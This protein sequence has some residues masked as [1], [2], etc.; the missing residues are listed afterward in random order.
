MN[1]FYK[2]SD[3]DNL[4]ISEIKHLYKNYINPE[5]VNIYNA[6]DYN[7]DIFEK[8]EGVYILLRMEKDF[9]FNWRSR[10]IKPWPQSQM[11]NK[12]RIKFQKKNKIEI[13]KL[14]LSPYIA[15]LGHNISI[16]LN[17]KLKKSY[18]VNSGAE[19]NEG[20]IKMAYAS[21]RN[22]RDYILSASNSFHGKLIATGT[23]TGSLKHLD[24]PKMKNVKFFEYNNFESLIKTI[25][26][27]KKQKNECNVYAI[28]IEPF[29]AQSLV[30]YDEHFIKKTRKLCDNENI[31]LIF[32]EVYCGWGKT[33]HVFSFQRYKYYPDILTFSKSFG[34]GKSSI[35]GY[36][37]KDHVFNKAYGNKQ[38]ALLHT[39]TYNGFAEECLTAI[40]AINILVDDDYP[41]KANQIGIIL[42][43]SL[44]ILKSKHPNSV[45]EIK[46]M[47]ALYGV[48]FYSP[49]DIFTNFFKNIPV[50]FIQ[51]KKE[52]IEKITI[53]SIINHLYSNHNILT[54]VTLNP[55]N[56]LLSVSPSLVITNEDI[57]YFIDS[58]DKTLQVGLSKLVFNFIKTNLYKLLQ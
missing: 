40:E 6:F 12:E 42:M 7:D 58:L 35:S 25:D 8:A 47:G 50:A 31:N 46:G 23:I 28:I 55:G 44:N 29:I 38:S 57:K 9:R 49:L 36:I 15:A 2:I 17:H 32:D 51:N 20:A 19:A 21:Y 3:I 33:G 30:G 5:Q 22:K 27:V 43:R 1:K 37:A 14:N 16:I 53:G 4:T 56:P 34:G 13:N 45:K 48:S 11:H 39:S 10:C 18:F 26:S 52:F 54:T 24:F 41:R